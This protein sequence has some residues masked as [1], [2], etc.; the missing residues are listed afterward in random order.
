MKKSLLIAIAVASAGA[1]SAAEVSQGGLT[2]TSMADG[3]AS[4]KAES[5]TIE[6][7]IVIPATVEIDGTQYTVT[8][9]ADSAFGSCDKVTSVVL[10]PTLKSIGARGFSMCG[11]KQITFPDGL[12]TIGEEA[13]ASYNGV[14]ISGSIVIPVTV[15]YIGVRA[16]FNLQLVSVD[17]Q[18]DETSPL[19]TIAEG[20]FGG[21]RSALKSIRVARPVPPQLGAGAFVAKD[22]DVPVTLY[23]AAASKLDEYKAAPGWSDMKFNVETPVG[24]TA[25]YDGDDISGYDAVYTLSG[26]EMTGRDLK[27]GIYIV[28]RGS[29]TL[30]VALP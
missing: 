27:P 1:M 25:V 23:G 24:I 20:A 21:T 11:I 6:G 15:R 17:I 12:E 4:V 16:F 19:L 28:R 10:P 3:T 14:G 22:A 29:R 13:F 2:F 18:G 26:M 30:K 5:K 8:Q 9:V 7:D